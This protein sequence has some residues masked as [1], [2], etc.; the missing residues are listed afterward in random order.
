MSEY[1]VNPVFRGETGE[2]KRIIQQITEQII[3]QLQ[4]LKIG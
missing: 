1:A 4:S 2:K 3:R